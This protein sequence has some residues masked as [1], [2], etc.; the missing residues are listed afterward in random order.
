MEVSESSKH[1]HETHAYIMKELVSWKVRRNQKPP[2]AVYVITRS[3]ISVTGGSSDGEAPLVIIYGWYVYVVVVVGSVGDVGW[4]LCREKLQYVM[5]ELRADF[6]VVRGNLSASE[7]NKMNY[8]YNLIC[9]C[10]K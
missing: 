3:L 9:D 2:T 5:M 4:C 6:T 7:R 1:S 10:L 8:V